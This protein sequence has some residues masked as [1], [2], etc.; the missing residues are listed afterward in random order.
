MKWR[1]WI[2][3]FW[4][5]LRHRDPEIAEIIVA[6]LM[7]WWGVW[8]TLPINEVFEYSIFFSQ[9]R[10]IASEQA[11]AILAVAIGVSMLNSVVVNDLTNR[12]RMTFVACIIWVSCAS[13]AFA[14]KEMEPLVFYSFFAAVSGWNYYRLWTH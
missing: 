8:H 5:I 13:A 1:S 9:L 2:Q 3:N 7:I 10:E 6:V 4:M 11:W 14:A 12:K